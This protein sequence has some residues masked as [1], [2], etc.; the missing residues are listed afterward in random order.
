MKEAMGELNMTVVTIVAIAAIAAFFALI[1]PGIRN[2]IQGSWGSI[3][4]DMNGI[5]QNAEIR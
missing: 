5:H 2:S 4:N 1:W 3:D